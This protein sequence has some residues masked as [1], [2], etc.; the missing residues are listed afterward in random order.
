M[1]ANPTITENQAA[2]LPTSEVLAQTTAAQTQIQNASLLEQSNSNQVGSQMT[3][4]VD[5]LHI[6]LEQLSS[7]K[8]KN[9]QILS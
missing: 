8:E 4:C 1:S 5:P 9:G 7:V 6:E 2:M 3:R